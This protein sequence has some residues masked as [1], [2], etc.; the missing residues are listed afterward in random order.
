MGQSPLAR[1]RSSSPEHNEDGAY[2]ARTEE[3]DEDVQA[4]KTKLSVLF[5]PFRHTKGFA[6]RR[7]SS[8]R[9]TRKQ[10]GSISERSERSPSGS[11]EDLEGFIY[12]QHKN[13]EVS[14]LS[15]TASS[16]MLGRM[17]VDRK[18]RK[19]KRKRRVSGLVGMVFGRDRDAMS[20]NPY[21]RASMGA[22]LAVA[23]SKPGPDFLSARLIP[24]LE[25]LIAFAQLLLLN[26]LLLPSFLPM[27]AWFMVGLDDMM[28]RHG[29]SSNHALPSPK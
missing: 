7:E 11:Q 23:E 25:I 29:I 20:K 18:S 24:A 2:W 4:T 28:P 22:L 14:V 1:S 15:T 10:R 5:Q 16:A 6:E 12:E 26:Q 13:L 27:T 9:R 21:A 17:L 3:N 19:S 8:P